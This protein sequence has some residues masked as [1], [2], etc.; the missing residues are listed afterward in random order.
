MRVR[1][2]SSTAE[3]DPDSSLYTLSGS[4]VLPT[5]PDLP[6]GEDAPT[7]TFEAPANA[8]LESN[9]KYFVVLDSRASEL[10]RFYKVFGTKSDAI[11]KVADGWSMNDFR[12]TGIRDTGV[13]TTA[14]EV[15]FVEVAGHAVVP[16]SDATLSG[17]SLTWDDG[18]TATDIA[19]DPVFDAATTAYTA[20]VAHAV[21][22]I[23]IEGDQGRQRCHGWTTSTARTR[24]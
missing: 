20:G 18:G 24:R 3:G 4:V 19:L 8:T 14:D 2:F 23:T 5:N 12:H 15:P 9:T 6:A 1:V 21:D 22:R 11:S 10:Y 17:L 7:S 13:W 16:S